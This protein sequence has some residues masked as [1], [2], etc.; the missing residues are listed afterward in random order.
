MK[1]RFLVLFVSALI[2]MSTASYADAP[3]PDAWSTWRYAGTTSLDLQKITIGARQAGMGEAFTGLADDL[4]TAS[5]NPA[6]FALLNYKTISAS[7]NEWLAESN[8]N[9]FHLWI[10]LWERHLCDRPYL[11]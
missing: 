6:G 4:N 10:T 8:Y 1:T 3:D 2:L 5:F 7:H 9:F 11:F